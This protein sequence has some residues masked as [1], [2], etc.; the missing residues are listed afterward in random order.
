[1]INADIAK[2]I[3]SSSTSFSILLV[4]FTNGLSGDGLISSRVSLVMV[5]SLG[6]CVDACDAWRRNSGLPVCGGG[7][8]LVIRAPVLGGVYATSLAPVLS[9]GFFLLQL[10]RV[11]HGCT[12][13]SS[14][15]G[16]GSSNAFTHA[17]V[18][19]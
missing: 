3:G 18:V 5:S 19:G 15:S 1:D 14:S 12:V 11:G 13:T 7:S 4:S 10:R 8:L 9:R 16:H 17:S 6:M 2:F